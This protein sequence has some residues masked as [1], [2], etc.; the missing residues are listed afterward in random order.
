MGNS[1]T[2][3]DDIG[4]SEDTSWTKSSP[5]NA[6]TEDK[7]WTSAP[8]ALDRN[9]TD[10]KFSHIGFAGWAAEE[11]MFLPEDVDV[12][13]EDTQADNDDWSI[14]SEPE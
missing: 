3:Q 8:A 10:N 13:P 1:W 9:V 2:I 7:A 6:G 5:L 14:S 11:F 12:N 4:D